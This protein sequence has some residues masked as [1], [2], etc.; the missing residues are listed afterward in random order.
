MLLL[1]VALISEWA[2]CS[3]FASGVP[4]AKELLARLLLLPLS[5]RLS[6]D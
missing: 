5:P 6:R 1:G 2:R 4:L 3:L